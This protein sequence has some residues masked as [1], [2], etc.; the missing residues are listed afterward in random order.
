MST[1]GEIPNPER[2]LLQMRMFGCAG[3]GMRDVLFE[4]DHTDETSKVWY[5]Q[6]QS[7]NFE[8]QATD[9]VG[10]GGIINVKPGSVSI[11]AYKR[12]TDGTKG[13]LVARATAPVR[14]KFLTI[15]IMTPLAE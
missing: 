14:A 15:V 12:M 10:S 4:A 9:D 2:G 7:A 8:A 6:G 3:V 11:K 1:S 13:E 5:A